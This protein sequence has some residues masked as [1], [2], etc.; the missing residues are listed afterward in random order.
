MPGV[1]PFIIGFSTKNAQAQT[2][3][4]LTEK[5]LSNFVSHGPTLTELAAAKRFLTGNFQLSLASNRSIADVLLRIA[6]YRLPSDY[7]T[8]YLE[9][10]Q[11][12]SASQ[13]KQAF[14]AHVFPEKLLQINV[15]KA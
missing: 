14:K 3:V 12:V 13:I 6:F 1:G 2:A 10:I 5:T 9:N 15:G 4:E 7:L 8:H 11:Q